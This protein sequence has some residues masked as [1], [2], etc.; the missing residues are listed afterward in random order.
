MNTPFE[1]TQHHID[2][3]S[4]KLSDHA[5]E[6]ENCRALLTDKEKQRA[7]HF[8]QQRDHERFILCRG[9]LRRILAT[10]TGKKPERLTFDRNENGK[11]FL[12][13]SGPKFNMSHSHNHLIVAVAS[14]AVGVDIEYYRD[15]INMEAIARRWFATNEQTFFRN[16]KNPPQ[17]FFE[18]WSKKEAYVKAL[19]QGIFHHLN[20]FTVPLNHHPGTPEIGENGVWFFQT[21]DI[22]PNYAAALVAKTPIR[23]IR[24]LHTNTLTS[25]P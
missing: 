19:G 13:E 6:L 4:I 16:S 9:L 18:I 25:Q 23:P 2:V 1:S 7:A 5:G 24:I 14:E 17:A 8:I 3:W 12:T 11:P 21:L 10:Y 15:T 22:A 20:S